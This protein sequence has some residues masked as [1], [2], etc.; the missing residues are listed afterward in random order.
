MSKF[1]IFHWDVFCTMEESKENIVTDLATLTRECTKV[2]TC[3]WLAAY[4]AQLIHL[5]SNT[6][7]I[8]ILK[9]MKNKRKKYTNK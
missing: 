3:S 1:H 4:S 2:K 5:Q 6:N 7:H 9:V 8:Y